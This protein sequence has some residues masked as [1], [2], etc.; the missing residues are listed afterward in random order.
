LLGGG[1]PVSRETAG[2]LHY[3]LGLSFLQAGQA[4]KA[5]MQ[6][7]AARARLSDARSLER[8]DQAMDQLNKTVK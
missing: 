4:D 3:Q 8:L 2:W 7:D 5:R 6:F 1:H